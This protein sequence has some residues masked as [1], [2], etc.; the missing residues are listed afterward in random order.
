MDLVPFALPRIFFVT[1][2][3]ANKTECCITVIWAGLPGQTLAY[4]VQS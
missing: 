2:N 3:W 4:P 1:Y